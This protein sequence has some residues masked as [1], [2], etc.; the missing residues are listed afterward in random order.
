MPECQTATSP[1]SPMSIPDAQ[2]RGRE[3][4]TTS[5]GSAKSPETAVPSKPSTTS[6]TAAT[7]SRPGSGGSASA[8]PSSR[9]SSA[10]DSGGQQHRRHHR[11]KQL[12]AVGPYLLGKTLG[13]GQT[14]LVKLAT[15]CKTKKKVAIKIIDR[16]HVKESVVR[17]VEREI[18]VMKLIQH[19]HLLRLFDVYDNTKYL[20]LVLEYVEGGELFDYLVKRGRLSPKEA[21]R[22]FRQIVS[23]ISYCHD[24]S[25]CHRDLKPEN[26][27]LDSKNDIRVADFGMANLQIEVMR[28]SCGSPHYAA[29]EV[30]MG[31]HY[32][33]FKADVWSCGVI[34]YA[35]LAG[36]LPFDDPN[37]STLL[38]K[39]KFGHFEMPAYFP[40]K[41]QRLIFRMLERN[42][43]NRISLKQVMKDDWLQWDQETSGINEMPGPET[44]TIEAVQTW[45]LK[46][47]EIDDDIFKNML[48]FTCFKDK[49]EL[50]AALTC[51]ERNMEK[52]VYF[53]LL[54][55]KGENPAVSD[56]SDIEDINFEHNGYRFDAR[57]RTDS[58]SS[59]HETR[60][61]SVSLGSSFNGQ[62]QQEVRSGSSAS[63][64]KAAPEMAMARIS[65]QMRSRTHSD[66]SPLLKAKTQAVL[67]VTP[68]PPNTGAVRR[69]SSP[70]AM[71]FSSLPGSPRESPRSSPRGRRRPSG[72]IP[73]PLSLT[74][75]RPQRYSVGAAPVTSPGATPA[76]GPGSVCSPLVSPPMSPHSNSPGLL[77]RLSQA[78]IG[79]TPQFHRRNLDGP[80]V[81]ALERNSL[82]TPSTPTTIKRS[83]FTNQLECDEIYFLVDR[84][85]LAALKADINDVL[86]ALD[87]D[88]DTAGS[89]PTVIKCEYSYERKYKLTK[90]KKMTFVLEL[91][92]VDDVKLKYCLTYTM[93][94][95]KTSGSARRFRGICERLQGYLQSRPQMSSPDAVSDD[96]VLRG[97]DTTAVATTTPSPGEA[98]SAYQS[99]ASPDQSSEVVGETSP[100]GGD[101]DT[102]TRG[103]PRRKLSKRKNF[104]RT[105]PKDQQEGGESATAAAAA[106]ATDTSPESVQVEV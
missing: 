34:L 15:H 74:A 93:T 81:T 65:D 86:K 92:A 87:V 59:T 9:P 66:C 64:G 35:L 8:G 54:R 20:F 60:A 43:A 49:D 44:E 37:L 32:D 98:D 69:D 55:R 78:F 1:T 90:H 22:L 62:H 46:D 38:E 7:T 51:E 10:P 88:V 89:T 5:S 31:E 105:Y 80:E 77:R 4:S 104:T 84:K 52:A 95:R 50:I 18:V 97:D 39:V 17:K 100:G 91:T 47:G 29:P 6:T 96:E 3:C 75:E 13:K 26:L 73:P 102:P 103:P 79:G 76:A 83:W 101:G 41:A 68:L 106:T 30:I 61:S 21:R 94:C 53:L 2:R 63:A 16:S 12:R 67:R 82:D 14:G 27:L 99:T 33:G 56:D 19:P 45:K 71:S 42:P 11:H 48:S 40:P 28:T 70:S 72:S 58:V 24:H 25:V 57:K 23:A 85:D 36:Q